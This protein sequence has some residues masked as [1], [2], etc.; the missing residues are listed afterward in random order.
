MT[1]TAMTEESEFADIYKL[2]VMEVPTNKPIARD[3][4]DDEL[5]MTA[6]EKYKA[7]ALQI[8]DCHQRGSACAGRHRLNRKVGI[9]FRAS[10]RQESFLKT[11]PRDTAIE[12]AK[13]LKDKDGDLKKE[14][15]ERAL[16]RWTSWR[17]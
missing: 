17:H 2:N 4:M 14:I 12:R 11:S 9:P 8:A 7:V 1:G 16:P 15:E 13:D 5:Y 6:D 3:D 10:Q